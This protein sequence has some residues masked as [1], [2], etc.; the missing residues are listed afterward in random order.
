MKLL[1]KDVLWAWGPAQQYAFE[2]LKR[3][4]T[5]APVLARPDFSKPFVIQTD[6]SDFAIRAA[7]IEEIKDGEHPIVFVSRVLTA[8][9][10]K[11]TAT[12]ECLAVLWSIEKLRPYIE[13]AKF[14]VITDH[15]ADWPGG[16]LRCNCTIWASQRSE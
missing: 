16:H 13:E 14:I 8:A 7:L 10:T 11:F 6:G 9:E 2:Q 5:E 12:E 1:C 4:L 15:R 3:S